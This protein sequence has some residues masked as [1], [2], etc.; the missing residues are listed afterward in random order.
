M[1]TI[2]QREGGPEEMKIP[3]DL[4][5]QWRGY[6]ISVVPVVLGDLGLIVGLRDH[7]RYWI[8]RK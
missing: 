6:K 3:A 1:G 8:P 4:A 2:G 7:P 5:H